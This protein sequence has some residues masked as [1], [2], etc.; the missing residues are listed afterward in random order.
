MD[1]I[2]KQSDERGKALVDHK[3]HCDTKELPDSV[4]PGAEQFS[5][6]VV[7]AARRPSPS[8]M[9]GGGISPKEFYKVNGGRYPNGRLKPSK[10]FMVKPYFENFGQWDGTYYPLAGFAEMA[11]Q[12]L[13][14]AA[15]L[16]DSTLKVHT[17]EDSKNWSRPLLAVEFEKGYETVGEMGRRLSKVTVPDGVK[18]TLAK[19]GIIDYLSNNQD[20]HGQNLMGKMKKNGKRGELKSVLAIDHGRSFQYRRGNRFADSSGS[21]EHF[22]FHLVSPGIRA[23]LNPNGEGNVPVDKYLTPQRLSTLV[24][25]WKDKRKEIADAFAHHIEAITDPTVKK[26]ISSN[27]KERMKTMDA[28]AKHWEIAPKTAKSVKDL[29]PE[30]WSGRLGKHATKFANTIR[31]NEHGENFLGDSE[32]PDEDNGDD[33][34]DQEERHWCA[35][36]QDYH[37][38]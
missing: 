10:T 21:M 5:K 1:R 11:T 19:I 23:A 24:A 34:F 9:W 2:H 12:G 25:W 30:H 16:G 18:D 27:F 29:D 35:V 36:C 13:M 8:S 3:V 32:E 26:W 33:D 7:K 4:Q 22:M 17:F 31:L 6:H 38:G 37:G 28:V 15:G 20:R 14:H